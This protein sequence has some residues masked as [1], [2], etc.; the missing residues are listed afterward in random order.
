TKDDALLSSP[1]L[2]LT[3]D[4]AGAGASDATDSIDA[5]QTSFSRDLEDS[6]AF[7]DHADARVG[8]SSA[9]DTL[10]EDEVPA[11]E[12]G[13]LPLAT[14]TLAE[15]YEG[16]GFF[17]KALEVY[18]DLLN[19]DPESQRLKERVTDLSIRLGKETA[20]SPVSGMFGSSGIADSGLTL[21]ASSADLS[22]DDSACLSPNGQVRNENILD[23]LGLWLDAIRRRK[24][25]R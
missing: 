8:S 19:K 12:S 3:E 21:G 13:I 10:S 11:A 23:L 9:G 14:V 4:T 25:C 18:T 5:E 6:Y 2:N 16:Q 20:H 17:E 22:G 24:E 15:L 7:G 1:A